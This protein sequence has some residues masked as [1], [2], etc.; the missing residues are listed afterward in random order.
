MNLMKCKEGRNTFGGA[1]IFSGGRSL[2]WLQVLIVIYITC[3]STV[4]TQPGF[5]SIDC[6]SNVSYTDSSGI[7]WE[8]DDQYIST[9]SNVNIALDNINTYPLIN[10]QQVGT[11]RIFNIERSRNCY[12]LPVISGNTYLVRTTFY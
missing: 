9:G 11:A 10:E 1:E 5:L 2:I 12:V 7:Y 4:R 6:G 8:T 3:V